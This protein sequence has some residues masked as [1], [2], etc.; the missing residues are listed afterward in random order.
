M[1]PEA[2]V[3][4]GSPSH[5]TVDSGPT[6]GRFLQDRL[7][8]SG[9]ET[10]PVANSYLC[11]SEA[12]SYQLCNDR[13]GS[14]PEVARGLRHTM[15]MSKWKRVAGFT[16]VEI[17]LVTTVAGVL[18]AVAAPSI[19]GAMR[20][21]RMNTATR[22]ITTEIRAARF[23][24][25]AKNR[26]MRVRFNCPGPG[27]FRVIEVTGNAAIDSAADRCSET[28]YPYPDQNPAVAPNAD[29]PAMWINQGAAL[30]A[31]QDL[32]ISNRG[33]IQPLNNCP[34]CAVAAPPAS[35]GIT[36]GYEIQTIPVS[37]SGMVSTPTY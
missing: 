4:A 37:A 22:T 36:N 14:D 27:Q 25:V 15:A 31:V 34:A 26:T 19:D 21:Y 6:A 29:G 12:P 28:A 13:R 1:T 24:A 8:A 9:A 33:R 35:I 3:L 30:G 11:V 7:L 18:A 23:I 5:L 16:L 17:M 2:S 20:R 32:Q 10:G